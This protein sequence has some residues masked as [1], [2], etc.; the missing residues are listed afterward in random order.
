[1]NFPLS[2]WLMPDFFADIPKDLEEAAMIDGS[3]SVRGLDFWKVSSLSTIA[4]IPPIILAVVFSRYL[5][6]FLTMGAIKE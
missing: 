6:R 1:M 2:V 3:L 5:V 4:I